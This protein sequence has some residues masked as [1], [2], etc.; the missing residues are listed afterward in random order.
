MFWNENVRQNG[1]HGAHNSKWR[2]KTQYLRCAMTSMIV[3]TS[4]NYHMV[5]HDGYLPHPRLSDQTVPPLKSFYKQLKIKQS[6]T[7]KCGNC[8]S[9]VIVVAGVVASVTPSMVKM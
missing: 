6:A 9:V 2:T 8:G 1:A 3:M 4:S 7:T 5:M